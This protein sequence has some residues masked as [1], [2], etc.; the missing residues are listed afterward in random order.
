MTNPCT[1]IWD[2]SNLNLLFDSYRDDECDIEALMVSRDEV[3]ITVD[4]GD[5]WKTR[6]SGRLTRTRNGKIEYHDASEFLTRMIAD[7]NP[8]L[9]QPNPDDGP[10]FSRLYR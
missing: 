2:S 10:N 9:I 4:F 6:Q 8:L 3:L 7:P 5:G 1:R